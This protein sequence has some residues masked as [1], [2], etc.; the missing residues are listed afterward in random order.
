MPLPLGAARLRDEADFRQ[1]GPPRTLAH[2]H[3]H[4]RAHTHTNT[5][6]HTHAY[7]RDFCDCGT[8]RRGQRARGRRGGAGPTESAAGPRAGSDAARPT[9]T[10][11]YKAFPWVGSPPRSP[12]SPVQTLDS[13][14]ARGTAVLPACGVGG[15]GPRALRI[16]VGAAGPSPEG[17]HRGRTGAGGRLSISPRSALARSRTPSRTPTPSLSLASA[18]MCARGALTPTLYVNGGHSTQSRRPRRSRSHCPSLCRS[19]TTCAAAPTAASS[20]YAPSP[21]GPPSTST[22]IVYNWIGQPHSAGRVAPLSLVLVEGCLRASRDSDR[23]LAARVR[24]RNR[25]L[26]LPQRSRSNL[27]TVG[28]SRR[29]DFY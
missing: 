21:A 6:T 18:L 23:A 5:H 19:G 13:T 20:A 26:R 22:L 7:M 24:Q 9:V 17:G 15:R 4:A 11:V 2:A 29:L 8:P 12:V 1:P 27:K 25:P 14:R 16:A 3:T 28:S 10:V